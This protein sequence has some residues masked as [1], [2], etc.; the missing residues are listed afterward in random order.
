MAHPTRDLSAQV[1]ALTYPHRVHNH[2]P[3]EGPGVTCPERAFGGRLR[4]LC[5]GWTGPARLARAVDD[6]LADLGD[7]DAD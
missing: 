6:A 2:G 7:S 5:L 1:A 4:G 3:D